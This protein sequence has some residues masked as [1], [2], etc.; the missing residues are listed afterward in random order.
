MKKFFLF[1]GVGSFI[2]CCGYF[3]GFD[4]VCLCWLVDELED[5]RLMG[6]DIVVMW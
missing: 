5:E 4:I 2:I 6:N 1:I 3:F